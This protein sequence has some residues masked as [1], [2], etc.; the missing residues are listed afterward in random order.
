MHIICRQC[1]KEFEFTKA[2]Q[3]FYQQKG[4][5]LPQRCK[6]CRSK[7]QS[8]ADLVVCTH[9]GAEIQKEGAVYCD[10]CIANYWLENEM[11]T[12]KI[13]TTIDEKSAKLEAAESRVQE[14]D[15]LL[16]E[17]ERL[18]KD[19]ELKIEQLSCALD[20]A[21]QLPIALNQWFQPRLNGVEE[22][23]TQ[24]LETLEKGQSKLNERIIQIAQKTFELF[25][26]ITLS[27]LVKRAF[28][29]SHKHSPQTE[30]QV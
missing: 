28:D 29:G 18:L 1:G 30:H 27:K 12:R 25:E 13:Q 3:E 8:E 5:T 24:R 19:Y 26:N 7:K 15:S 6:E 10:T 11:K 23:V 22:R 16:S 4:F 17:K 14:L 20:E 21:N 2:E 9:C